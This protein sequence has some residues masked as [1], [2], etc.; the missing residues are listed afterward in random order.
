VTGGR[1]TVQQRGYNGLCIGIPRGRVKRHGD[2]VGRS[3]MG[4]VL[5][6]LVAFSRFKASAVNGGD[7]LARQPCA[8]AIVGGQLDSAME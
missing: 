6:A 3:A 7:V 5:E 2:L 8:D 1:T 4:F